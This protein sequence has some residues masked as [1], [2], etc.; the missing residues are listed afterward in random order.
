M[1]GRRI[2]RAVSPY[3]MHPGL[4]EKPWCPSSEEN[5]ISEI[6]LNVGPELAKQ[7]YEKEGLVLRARHQAHS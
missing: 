4:F 3:A 5:F 6:T 1:P 2:N 7:R